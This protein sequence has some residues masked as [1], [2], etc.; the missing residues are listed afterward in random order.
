VLH[1]SGAESKSDPHLIDRAEDYSTRCF[2]CKRIRYHDVNNE[3]VWVDDAWMCGWCIKWMD[4]RFKRRRKHA[5]QFTPNE[6]FFSEETKSQYCKGLSYTAQDGL[7]EHVQRWL[8]EGKV[9]LGAP[10]IPNE[11]QVNG[12]GEVKPSAK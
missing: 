11:A 3:G 5:M 10:D 7:L 2:Y 9:R 12:A 4:G 1:G 8:E 6:D